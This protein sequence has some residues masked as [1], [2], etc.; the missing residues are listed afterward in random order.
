MS[1]FDE[2]LPFL[3]NKAVKSYSDKIA[4]II[5]YGSSV[6]GGST[7]FSDLDILAIVD[8]YEK[9]SLYWPF[10]YQGKAVEFWSMDWSIANRW[11]TGL[12]GITRP[13][14]LTASLFINSKIIYSRSPADTEK[15][16]AIVTSAL[17][18]KEKGQSNLNHAMNTLNRTYSFIPRIELAKEKNDLVNGRWLCCRLTDEIKNILSWLNCQ[19]YTG[20]SEK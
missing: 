11:A 14:G 8:D 9:F 17:K 13:W 12:G 19:Y 15:F 6:T 16:N 4:L 2:L 20:T 3:V 5:S 7:A 1:L 18:V 10:V